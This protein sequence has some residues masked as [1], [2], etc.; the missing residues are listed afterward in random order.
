MEENYCLQNPLDCLIAVGSAT[1]NSE[2][3]YQPTLIEQAEAVFTWGL[4]IAA[5]LGYLFG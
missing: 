2:P 5:T 1:L 4:G 3:V